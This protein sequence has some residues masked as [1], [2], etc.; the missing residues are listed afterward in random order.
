MR[1]STGAWTGAG[2]GTLVR[3]MELMVTDRNA[4][5][6]VKDDAHPAGLLSGCLLLVAALAACGGGEP[7]AT[8]PPADSDV[9][10]ASVV[11][12]PRNP[13]LREA[14]ATVAFEATAR[15]ADY[16]P[17]D[18][19]SFSW[20]VNDTATAEIS[21]D[22]VATARSRGI[23]EVAATA[24]GHTGTATLVVHLGGP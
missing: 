4:G 7:G 8:A 9:E 3:I 13:V 6:S 11:V 20:S 2:T 22:G 24:G 17:I 12:S 10:I 19:V 5:K 16:D 23:V 14:G 1:L 21:P 18:G 15:D